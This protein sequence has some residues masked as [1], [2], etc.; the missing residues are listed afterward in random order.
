VTPFLDGISD[1]SPGIN[2]TQT[3]SHALTLLDLAPADDFRSDVLEGLAQSPKAIPCKYF[4]DAIG[5]RLFER[6]CAQPEYYPTCTELAIM[7]RH[8]RDMAAALGPQCLLIEYGS[9][10]GVKSRLLLEHLDTPAGYVPID[11]AREA[12]LHSA[13]ALAH[14]FADLE[15]LPVCAD[16]T[17][18]LKLPTPARTPR[19]RV[20]YFPGS[21]IG[22]LTPDEAAVLLR[23]TTRLCGPG[24]GLLLGVDLKKD[25]ALLHAAYNDRGGVTAAFNLNLLTR[26][27]RELGGDLDTARFWHHAFYNP[28]EGRIE[29][30]LV[31]RVEQRLSIGGES[32]VLAEGESIRTEYSYK[33]SPAEVHDL[34]AAG[35]FVVRQAWFDD[36]AW[37][38]VWEL[39]VA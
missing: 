6:I 30:H 5:S 35:G 23:Q 16:F 27:N 32:I 21:T 8:V 1:S 14:R 38:G 17:Q 10:S 28:V 26:I 9:G 25:P 31:S 18:P 36:T 2:M 12:L 34:A 37:F 24:G 22:N 29:M 15:V 19:R 13:Q 33:Y 4:Y 20:V 11:V 39:V 7:R 3:V